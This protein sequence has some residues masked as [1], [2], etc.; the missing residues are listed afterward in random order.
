ME[1]ENGKVKGFGLYIIY[2][3]G[4]G[5]GGGWGNDWQIF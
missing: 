5:G 4:K 3:V 1:E 2:E